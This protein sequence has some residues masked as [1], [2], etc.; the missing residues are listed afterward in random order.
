MFPASEKFGCC[1][2]TRTKRRLFCVFRGKV[3]LKPKFPFVPLLLST[4]TSAAL[5]VGIFFF[6]RAGYFVAMFSGVP[7]AL[8]QIA[9]H[10][11][12]LGVGAMVLSG[13]VIEL[14]TRHPLSLLLYIAWAGMSGV[15]AGELVRRHKDFSSSVFAISL[16]MIAFFSFLMGFFYLRTGGKVLEGLKQEMFRSFD[17][18]VHLYLQNAPSPIPAVDQALILKMEPELFSSFLT[19]IPGVF[20]ATVFLTAL[21]LM[22]MVKGILSRKSAAGFGYGIDRWV[23][24]DPL[25]FFLVLALALIAIPVHAARLAGVNLFFSLSILYV[26]QGAG[27]IVSYAKSRK[28]GRLFWIVAASFILLQP[29]ILLLLGIVGVLDVWVDFRK[30]RPSADDESREA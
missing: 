14:L 21:I 13:L 5:F 29:L 4:S 6:P 18:V 26:G 2:K 16:Q 22:G 28:F 10:R 30:I 8:A 24:W 12:Q 9:Y 3:D 15:L 25:I 1:D 17:Q 11:Y 19:L 20:V 27:V 7:L 23:L